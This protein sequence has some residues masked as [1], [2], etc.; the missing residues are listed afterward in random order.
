VPK[1]CFSASAGATGYIYEPCIHEPR[2]TS[3]DWSLSFHVSSPREPSSDREAADLWPEVPLLDEPQRHVAAT[4]MRQEI[5]HQLARALSRMN[6]AEADVIL[7]ECLAAA[8]S[9]TR[10][11]FGA[12]RTTRPW[13]L[14]R[15]HPDLKLRVEE[16]EAMLS[17]V[18]GAPSAPIFGLAIS[19]LAR[20]AIEMAATRPE[21][22]VYDLPGPWTDDERIALGDSLEYTGFFERVDE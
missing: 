15:S 20:D 4:R 6:R 9:V 2:N 3:N 14:K 1:N 16:N 10:R 22:D 8:S 11:E 21:I 18:G 7:R 17:L 5:A 12:R 13:R 19:E